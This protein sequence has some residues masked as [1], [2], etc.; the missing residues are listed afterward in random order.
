MN[1][2]TNKIKENLPEMRHFARKYLKEILTV[3]ALLAA[4]FS[5][6][7]GVFI[8]GV[9]LSLLFSM[10]GM[11]VGMIIP[12][13]V[14]RWI[15][16]FYDMTSKK[17]QITEIVIECSKIVGAFFFSFAYFFCM[18]VLAA[19]SYHYFSHNANSNH[20]RDWAA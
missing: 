11:L 4:G 17:S 12:K 9:G 8:N 1:K 3:L 18:G 20:G 13:K 2:Y 5:A 7:K 6:W 16:K 19:S 15:H 10:I 14:N